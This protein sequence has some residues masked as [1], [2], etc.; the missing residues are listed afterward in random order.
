[1]A[2]ADQLVTICAEFPSSPSQPADAAAV[3]SEIST[4]LLVGAY[5]PVT[6]PEYAQLAS[7]TLTRATIVQFSDQGHG[8]LTSGVCA[9]G[10]IAQFLAQPERPPSAGCAEQGTLEFVL[11]QPGN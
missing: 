9:V 4:L 2:Y 10:I 6:P 11:P 8:A 1:M 5:D 3:S 7:E